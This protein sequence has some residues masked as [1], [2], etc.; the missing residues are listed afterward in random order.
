ML[1][2]IL[3]DIYSKLQSQYGFCYTGFISYAV[4]AVEFTIALLLAIPKT[5]FIALFASF[6]LMLLFTAYIIVILNYSSFV[7]CSCGGILEQLG[8]K[9]HL[10]FNIVFTLLAATA[11]LILSLDKIDT[12]IKLLII[13]FAGTGLIIALYY[14]SEN[15]MHQENPFIRRFIQGSATKVSGVN[16]NNNTLYFAGS[17]GSTFYLGDYKAPLHIFAYD[18]LLKTK[19]HYKIQLEREDFPFQSAQVKVFENYFYLMDGTVPVIYKGTISDWKAKVVM[20]NNNYYF[21]KAEIITPDKIAFRAQELKTGHNILGTFTFSDTLKVEYAP[22]LLQKQV[23]GFFDTDGMMQF[24]K[25]THKLIYL[26]YYRNQFIVTDNNLKLQYR[27]K[28]IDTTTHAKLKVAY[29][30]NTG[31]RKLAAPPFTVNQLSTV[32]NNLLF[33][34]SKLIGKYE[35]KE[36]WKEAS[37]ID[38]YDIRQNSYLSSI[39]IYDSNKSKVNDMLVIGNNLYAIVG[40]QLHKYHLSNQFIKHTP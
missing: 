9:E 2:A 28:T 22:N 40:H 35:P 3:Q 8:W 27:G 6:T 31:Q 17:D 14:T 10:I 38:V 32:N 26:Y 19:K 20:S 7:P 29:I 23:D 16:L 15:A 5:R 36:M 11:I 12:L 37:I 34:N 24:D 1:P 25:Q 39:Y 18:T 4:L 21:S 13:T 30:R 33:V